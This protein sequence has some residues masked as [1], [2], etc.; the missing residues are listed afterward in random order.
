MK[1]IEASLLLVGLA[2]VLALGSGC[3][4][5][6][7]R[8]HD[9]AASSAVAKTA[10]SEPP[11]DAP[12]QPRDPVR[13]LHQRTYS[14]A[15]DGDVVHAGTTAGVVS[16]D[17]SDPKKPEV[18]ATLVLRDSVQHLAK[19]PESDLIA[20]ATG[21]TGIALVDVGSVRS[22]TL[23]L[24]NEHPWSKEARE[25]CHAAWRLLPA[26]PGVGFVACGG[27]GVARVNLTDAKNPKVDR[28]VSVDGYV[29]DLSLLDEAAGIPKPVASH[30]K[31]I[32]AAGV[33]GVAVVD[34]GG[35]QPRV[36]ANLDVGGEARAVEAHG[37]HAYVAAGA[38]GLVVVDVNDPR[39]PVVVGSLLP[40]TTDMARGIAISG[41]HALLCLGDS[42]LVVADISDPREPKE[43]G[44][45]DP[46]RA[47][48]RVTVSGQRLFAANDAD[49]VA[50][51]DISNPSEPTQVF[52]PESK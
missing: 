8:G 2:L 31:V 19:I 23:T 43:I 30:Q 21:P 52:P 40:K 18:I 25:G 34:F 38:A 45:F 13:P 12:A 33:R 28:R 17:F 51:L 50:I 26:K 24:V 20:V 36:L 14:I 5:P 15:V 3:K 11:S 41:T 46:K 29:R 37:G 4:K 27:G 22:K 48:N 32:A 35:I 47:L 1:G 6:K 9:P 39:A 10:P 44:R 42:G 7:W 49:G 16:W